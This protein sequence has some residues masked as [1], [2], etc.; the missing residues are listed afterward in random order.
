MNN[1]KADYVRVGFTL[2]E[3]LITLGVIGVVAAMTMPSVINHYQK[4]ATVNKLKKFYTNMNQVM[5]LAKTDNG[6]F[7]TWNYVDSEEFYNN[8]IK[9]YIKNVDKVQTG[10]HIYGDF[11]GGVKFIFADGTFAILSVSTKIKYQNFN[12][13]SSVC[14]IYY[15]KNFKYT[16]GHDN[17]KYPTHERFYFIVNSNGNVIPPHMSNSR[18][19]NKTNCKNNTG[20]GKFGDNGHTDCATLIYKDGWKISDDYP[21]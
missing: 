13:G 18:D 10:I 12:T 5:T 1:L 4:Q 20:N 2:A 3:V 6:D 17:I 19:I 16:D 9:P 11:A 21:W 15:P 7:S 14:I 8:Y